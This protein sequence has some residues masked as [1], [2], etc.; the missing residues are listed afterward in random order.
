MSTTPQGIREV[1]TLGG[2]CF[3]CLEAVYVELAGV[4]KVVSGY[5]GG[6][7]P[8]PSYEQVCSG[9]TGHAEV[10]QVTY[11][12][13]VISFKE[14]LEVF[15]TIHDPTTPNRQGHDVGTQYRSIILYHTAEQRAVAEQTIADL[16][17]AG[18]WDAPIVTEVVPLEA[19]YAAEAYHQDYFKNN[20]YQPYCQVVVAPKVA[21]ARKHF[22]SKLKK[23]A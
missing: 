4:E 5:A 19:F 14:L 11:D 20:P 8:N 22:L 16:G 18:L 12:P 6:R 3:W 17:K 1:A 10:I 7:R 9:A 23:T 15:F 13:Q 2:G 21:K